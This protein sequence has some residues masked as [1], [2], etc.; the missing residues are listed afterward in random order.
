M[1]T[2]AMTATAEGQASSL[3]TELS[4]ADCEARLNRLSST[5]EGF[6]SFFQ[7]GRC[8]GF[9]DTAGVYHFTVE[10]SLWNRLV[11]RMNGG[12]YPLDDTHAQVVYAF[13]KNR[14]LENFLISM[15]ILFGILPL[16]VYA[17]SRWTPW[18][19]LGVVAVALVAFHYSLFAQGR[20]RLDRAIRARLSP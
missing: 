5:R 2:R 18:I 7:V 10:G 19:V 13:A 11:G 14:V 17:F 3:V 20:I 12:V 4:V 9:Y 16:A 15:L 6:P 1:L 8:K